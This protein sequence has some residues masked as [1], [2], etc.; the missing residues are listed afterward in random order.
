M[1]PDNSARTDFFLRRAIVIC[2]ICLAIFQFSE[3]TADPDLWGHVIYGNHLLETGHLM[4]A[5]PYS[6][7][8]PGHQ[9]INHEILAEAIMA[10]SF[11]VLGG[12]GLLLLTVVIGLLTFFIA[13]TT[14][15]KGQNSN[16]KIVAWA[17]GALAVVEISFGFA[18][19]PQIF[20]A[21]ALAVEVWLLYQFHRGNWRCVMALP[22]LFALWINT[23]GGAIVGIVLLFVA[24]AATT[25]QFILVKATPIMACLRPENPLSAKAIVAFW[26]AAV[27]SAV[28]LVANPYGLSLIRWL[29]DSISWLRPQIS[30][31]NPVSLGWDHAAFF[32]CV[33]LAAFAFLFSSRPRF[34]WEIAVLA[35]LAVM[36]FRAVRNTPLFCL[37][38][39]ALVPPHLAGALGRFKDHFTGLLAVGRQTKVKKILTTILSL[40][41]VAIL[42]CTFFLHKERAW[43]MEVP[44]AQYPVSAINFIQQHDLHGNLLV[45][46]DWGEMCLWELPDSRVSIDGRL[47]TCY[48]ADVITAHWQLYDAESFDTKALDLDHA[49]F[50][51][52][53]SNLAGSLALAKNYGWHPVYLDGLAVVLVKNPDKF[54]A[55]AGIKLPVEAGADAIQG[56]AAFPGSLPAR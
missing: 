46:F 10:L 20:T 12:T 39:L 13:L 24:L 48:P 9:W 7:T 27:L 1:P 26:L 42:A 56:R 45:Y 40:I 19:R 49:E 31:W 29:I 36:A 21:L 41:A 22:I 4:R 18:A 6:W 15:S 32:F 52:L 53:P 43:T 55:L 50:A 17:F 14:A 25:A 54:P 47:D 2:V 44:R 51:L 34:L 38:A 23:H 28:A 16:A 35:L 8:A 5:D 33:T 30:E 3:N 11:R 37:A